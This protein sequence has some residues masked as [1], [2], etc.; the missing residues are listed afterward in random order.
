M[1]V[2]EEEE[3]GN[4]DDGNKTPKE[5]TPRAVHITVGPSSFPNDFLSSK[6]PT[7]PGY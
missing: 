1:T 3:E 2:E 6:I 7:Q 5:S 4:D